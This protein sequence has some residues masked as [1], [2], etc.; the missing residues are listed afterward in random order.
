MAISGPCVVAKAGRTAF[1]ISTSG[2]AD[3]SLIQKAH[4]SASTATQV[5][6]RTRRKL[7]PR[8]ASVMPVVSVKVLSRAR[9]DEL[10]HIGRAFQGAFGIVEQHLGLLLVGR[11]QENDSSLTV[12]ACL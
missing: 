5:T 6:P 8:T 9:E 1:K 7:P 12:L 11:E 3:S 4:S 2:L 10:L